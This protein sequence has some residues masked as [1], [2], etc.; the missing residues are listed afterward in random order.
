MPALEI[1]GLSASAVALATLFSTCVECFGFFRAAQSFQPDMETALAKLDLEKTRLLIW[2]NQ[3]GILQA[4]ENGRHARLQ[5]EQI[6]A[7]LHTC[8]KQIENLLS[9]TEQ[10]GAKYG[11]RAASRDEPMIGAASMLSTNSMGIFRA[12]CLRPFAQI[13]SKQ[14]RPTLV[15]RTR[16]AIYD[17]TKF[18]GLVNDLTHFID[19]LN[20][21]LSVDRS[22]QDRIVMANIETIVDLRLLRLVR[23]ASED[24]YSTWSSKA[25]EIIE[26][27]EL[28]TADRRNF[29]EHIRDIQGLDGTTNLIQRPSDDEQPTS[30]LK[31]KGSPDARYA[32]SWLIPEERRVQTPSCESSW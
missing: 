4:T 6:L 27:S 23:D 11:M 28:G 30:K 26:A 8:L 10:L 20:L 12:S 15:T 16:W 5:E 31:S 18:Q 14:D 13:S 19:R 25:S 7:S 2:G 24:V 32:S 22:A 21:I 17:K 9:N 3:I 1:F 29:E